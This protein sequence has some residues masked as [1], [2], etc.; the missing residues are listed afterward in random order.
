M[1]NRLLIDE[2]VPRELRDQV[3]LLAEG[4]QTLWVTGY[5]ISEY[6][7]IVEETHTILQAKFYGGKAYGGPDPG[8]I[9]RKR[10]E[11]EDQ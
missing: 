8:T 2:K 7:K 6:Y 1:V 3:L 5:R 4:H 11:S 9:V 10:S